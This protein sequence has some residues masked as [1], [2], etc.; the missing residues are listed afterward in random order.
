MRIIF[1][2]TKMQLAKCLKAFQNF[3]LEVVY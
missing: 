2:S 1:S 3:Y